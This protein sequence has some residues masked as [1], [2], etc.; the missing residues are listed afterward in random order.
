MSKQTIF[1]AL[2]KN[3]SLRTLAFKSPFYVKR[4]TSAFRDIARQLE[5]LPI[6]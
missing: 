6:Y 5:A 1:Q 2:E 4:K 3:V